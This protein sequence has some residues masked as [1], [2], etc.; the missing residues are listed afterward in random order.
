MGKNNVALVTGGNGGIGEEICRQL[1]DTGCKVV[2]GYY[3]ADKENAE[4]W[5]ATMKAAGHDV[6]LAAMD[7][8]DYD[9]TQAV[10]ADIESIEKGSISNIDGK[11][12]FND[13]PEGIY[14]VKISFT[15][16]KTIDT[17][18]QFPLTIDYI[19]YLEESNNELN[20]FTVSTTRSTRTI[21]DIP[22]R[23]EFIGG[24][25]LGEKAIM[26][27]ANISMVLTEPIN[28]SPAMYRTT[29]S[30]TKMASNSFT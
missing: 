25:E 3:P 15:G 30:L 22:T 10:I 8:T 18:I 5:Q 27:S 26:N 17:I 12:I 1:T 4:A 7:V 19:F 14:D 11:V 13:V 9:A 24:E 16:F 23:M 29:E 6:E 28:S 20:E 21:E 2:A